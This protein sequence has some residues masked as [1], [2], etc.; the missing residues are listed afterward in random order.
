MSPA[1]KT[2]MA[3]AICCAFCICLLLRSARDLL[4]ATGD[5]VVATRAE[6]LPWEPTGLDARRALH[7]AGAGAARAAPAAHAAARAAPAAHA[8]A[9]AARGTSIGEAVRRDHGLADTHLA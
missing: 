6:R 5:A 1:A 9:R 4:A 2:A 3:R 8:A 7:A